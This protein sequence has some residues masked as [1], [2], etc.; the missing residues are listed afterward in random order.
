MPNVADM[1]KKSLFFENYFNHTFPTYKGLIG[2]LFSGYQLNNFD[3]N[4]LVS[5]EE[6][7][8][9]AGYHTSFINTEPQ[10][11][12][13]ASYL[14]NLR[15]DEVVTNIDIKGEGIGGSLHLRGFGLFEFVP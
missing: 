5:L 6:A 13:F 7:F 2:Q 8:R 14:E 11:L 4:T 12:N 9:K 3:E 10:N 1:E 15:F